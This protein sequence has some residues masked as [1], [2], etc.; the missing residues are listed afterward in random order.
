MKEGLALIDPINGI[1]LRSDWTHD[2]VIA[3]FTKWFP[4]VF[5]YWASLE[6]QRVTV[7]GEDGSKTSTAICPWVQ[8]AQRRGRKAKLT[9]LHVEYPAGENLYGHRGRGHRSFEEKVIYIGA[10]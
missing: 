3:A 9:I 8:C 1:E 5:E 6:P 7:T 2:E 10:S 4:K